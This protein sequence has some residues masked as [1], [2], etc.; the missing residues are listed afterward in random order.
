M[1]KTAGEGWRSNGRHGLG[2]M[3]S[4]HG[5]M[6]RR[7]DWESSRLLETARRNPACG[8]KGLT[9][10]KPTNPPVLSLGPR[11]PEIA[12]RSL[13]QDMVDLTR[14]PKPRNRS[15]CVSM[16]TIP[17]HRGALMTL[18]Q[19]G[20][21]PKLHFQEA[22]NPKTRSVVDTTVKCSQRAQ[23]T[24]IQS[25]FPRNTP[26]ASTNRQMPHNH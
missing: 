3:V 10:V 20:F 25:F 4:L 13:L 15:S 21:Q 19:P 5:L 18:P 1:D 9:P 16:P 11:F 26:S 6:S 12:P 17:A 24:K 8:K 7:Q 22:T 23:E 2:K 14:S